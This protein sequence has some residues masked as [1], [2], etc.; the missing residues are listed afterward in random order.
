M[1]ISGRS[2]QLVIAQFLLLGF[3]IV[4]GPWYPASNMGLLF[5]VA[6]WIIG[7]AAVWAFQ[8]SKLSVFPEPNSRSQLL[9]HG[10]FHYIRHP[11]YTAVLLIAGSLAFD[12]A[13]WM[14]MVAW[15]LLLVVLLMKMDH[16]EGL[17]LQKFPAYSDYKKKTWRLIPLVY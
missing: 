4:T 14:R 16:E 17:L 3:I 10:I 8:R 12:Q 15:V 5:Y 9:T 13:S 6:G 2:W 11:L 7:I 1:Q